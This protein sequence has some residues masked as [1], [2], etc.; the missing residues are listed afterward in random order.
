MN[1]IGIDKAANSELAAAHA[2]QDHVFNDQ[3]RTGDRKRLAIITH[4]GVPKL[5]A[6]C[7]VECHQMRVERAIENHVLVKRNAAIV[8]AAAEVDV[9]EVVVIT[10]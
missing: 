5:S 6:S 1:I 2:D 10:P 7:R 9:F 4:L 8:R 3:R